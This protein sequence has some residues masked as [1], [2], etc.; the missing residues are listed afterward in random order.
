[1]SPDC[2]SESESVTRNIDR[3]LGSCG[4]RAPQAVSIMQADQIVVVGGYSE[5]DGICKTACNAHSL[6]CIQNVPVGRP[7]QYLNSR[8]CLLYSIYNY[9]SDNPMF[10]FLLA[11]FL[12]SVMRKYSGYNYITFGN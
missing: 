9:L 1:M 8:Q 10:F 3:T 11:N 4:N 5:Y 6:F 12:Q 7:V 2:Q